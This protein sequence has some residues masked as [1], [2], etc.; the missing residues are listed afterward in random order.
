MTSEA[1]ATAAAMTELTVSTVE[2]AERPTAP[3]KIGKPTMVL[4][5]HFKMSVD[6]S[7]VLYHYRVNIDPETSFRGI[8]RMVV[9][10]L[11]AE[12]FETHAYAYDG[13]F[14]AW[15]SNPL[16]LGGEEATGAKYDVILDPQKGRD[17]GRPFLVELKLVDAAPLQLLKDYVD[18]KLDVDARPSLQIQAIEI[19]LSN[20]AL[21]QFTAGGRKFYTDT[22]PRIDIGEALELWKGFYQSVR[23]T[24]KGVMLNF[25]LA[26]TAFYKPMP[27]LEYLRMVCK[28]GFASNGS[29]PS[30]SALIDAKKKITKLFCNLVHLPDG[31]KKRCMGLTPESA[32][33]YKFQLG[34][35]GPEI[36][37]ENYYKE[38]RGIDLKYAHLPCLMFGAGKR[39]CAVPIEL[40]A[41]APGQRYIGKLS[42]NQTSK[43]IKAVVQR[44]QQRF[45]DNLRLV[46]LAHKQGSK[47]AQE[48]GVSKIDTDGTKVQA[49]LLGAP[50]L[51]YCKGAKDTAKQP[52]QWNM[53]SGKQFHQGAHLINMVGIAFCNSLKP[54]DVKGFCTTLVAKCKQLG[55]NVNPDLAK[56]VKVVAGDIRN[57]RQSLQLAIK[58]IGGMKPPHLPMVVCCIPDDTGPN[59]CKA[60]LK[61][62]AETILGI[63]TQCIL[64]KNVKKYSKDEKGADQFHANV[65]LKVNIK[66]GG[67]NYFVDL[68]KGVERFVANEPTMIIGADVTHPAPGSTKF[69]SIA[70][71]AGSVDWPYLARF[72]TLCAAQAGRMVLSASKIPFNCRRSH[73]I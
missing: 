46:K 15:T 70:A 27:C 61:T 26:N 57:M 7:K 60:L 71:V 31:V 2:L 47:L 3:A 13:R 16:D 43:V 33:E 18:G 28:G 9:E 35:E 53:T 6:F 12:K 38:K 25:D 56:G 64:A 63:P 52:G 37:I 62:E 23:L 54:G 24:Q 1:E 30:R 49:R 22:F 66:L 51:V 5:N 44:P 36:T 48:F 39:A 10:K 21:K 73:S 32:S 14:D 67:R 65:A 19:M 40:C 34:R 68:K 58:S 69:P 17:E 29:L 45:A 55:M 41:I 11:F 72:T 4:A 59:S 50:E 42:A 8:N 20:L